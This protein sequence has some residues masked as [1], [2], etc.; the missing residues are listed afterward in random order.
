MASRLRTEHR[1]RVPLLL[2]LQALRADAMETKG[3]AVGK[4]IEMLSKM[5]ADGEAGKAKEAEIFKSIEKSVANTLTETGIEIEHQTEM[6]DKFE[7][8][9]EAVIATRLSW[10]SDDS[11][12][13]T[14]QSSLRVPRRR[15]LHDT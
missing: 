3:D 13:A 4:V 2:G 10:S 14:T 8:C 5:I 7:A 11:T 6:V 15:C 9:K 1:M 12:V